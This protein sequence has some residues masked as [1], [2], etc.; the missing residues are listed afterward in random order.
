MIEIAK[1]KFSLGKLVATP[2]AL[3]AL[4]EAGQSPMEFVSRHL[5]GDWGEC[6]EEDRQTNEDALQNGE[7][8]FSVYRTAKGVKV[9]VITETDRSVTTMLLPSEY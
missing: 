6:C 7:R 3:D 4:A 5:Q 9:W 1:P 2:G 8:L